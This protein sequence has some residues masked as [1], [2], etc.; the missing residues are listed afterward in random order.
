MTEEHGSGAADLPA[1]H[2]PVAAEAEPTL[3]VRIS[4]W[5]GKRPLSSVIVAAVVALFVGMGIGSAGAMM[6]DRHGFGHGGQHHGWGFDEDG[7]FGNGPGMMG[8]NGLGGPVQGGPVQGGPG[9]M[10]PN[11]QGGPGVNGGNGG[12]WKWQP[13]GQPTPVT[14]P[15]TATQ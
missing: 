9:M 12:T 1:S 2:E 8:P 6:H 10:G 5:L 7:G 4:Q 14:T 15:S 3:R 13:N 11:G